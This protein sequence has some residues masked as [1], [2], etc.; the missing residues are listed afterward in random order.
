MR[1]KVARP[2]F[3]AATIPPRPGSVSTS[4]A[5]DF[6]TS[7]AEATATPIWACRRAGASLAPSPHM[8]TVW[9]PLW[10]AFTSRNLSS[11]NTPANTA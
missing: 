6:A 7:V 3:T 8:P 1:W 11:G 4:P 9:P 2:S 5:A 10:S